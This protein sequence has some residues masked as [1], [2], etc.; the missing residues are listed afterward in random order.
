MVWTVVYI[1]LMSSLTL[2]TWLRL[3]WLLG[4][5][6]TRVETQGGSAGR[7]ISWVA[8]V[9]FF[10]WTV[11]AGLKLRALNPDLPSWALSHYY[12]SFYRALE[13]LVSSLSGIAFS[14]MGGQVREEG[15][16]LGRVY[17]WDRFLSY[18][19]EENTIYLNSNRVNLFGRPKVIKVGLDNW[20]RGKDLVLILESQ[21][22]RAMDQTG[23]G[24][25]SLR[26]GG[27]P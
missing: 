3:G 23:E 14:L 17:T 15:M 9:I 24:E 22:I 21:G 16:Y 2:L 10:A 26:V 25:S 20:S 11:S 19:I 6:V 8:T 1:S 13:G 5:R 4:P 7:A 12:G 27:L 18:R